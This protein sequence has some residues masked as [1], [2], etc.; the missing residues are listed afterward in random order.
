MAMFTLKDCAKFLQISTI[1]IRS[2]VENQN[3]NVTEYNETKNRR[4][5]NQIDRLKNK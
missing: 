1:T 4:F 2:W 3:D 5:L